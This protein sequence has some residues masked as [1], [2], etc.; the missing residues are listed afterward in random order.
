MKLIQVHLSG[1]GLS[2]LYHLKRP[3]DLF[4]NLLDAV[5]QSAAVV[6]TPLPLTRQQ[7]AYQAPV[8]KEQMN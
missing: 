6:L 1:D 3:C 4:N 2:H 5:Y 8:I 7:L